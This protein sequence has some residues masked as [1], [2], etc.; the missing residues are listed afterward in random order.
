MDLLFVSCD[1]SLNLRESDTAFSENLQNSIIETF[2]CIVHGL[3]E[4]GK[5]NQELQPHLMKI[6][7]FIRVTTAQDLHPTL[8]Y[9]KKCV[10][11]MADISNY[12]KNS[13]SDFVKQPYSYH[14]IEVL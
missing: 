9:V 12:Y 2:T 4:L 5:P 14:C 7:N 10:Q 13:V 3:N 1:Y 11:L 8:S 6:F